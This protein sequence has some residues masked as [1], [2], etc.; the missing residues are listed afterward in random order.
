MA[1]ITDMA[2]IFIKQYQ[3]CLYIKEVLIITDSKVFNGL[4]TYIKDISCN[5]KEFK[6]LL[7][8]FLFSNSFYTLEG[9]FQYSDTSANE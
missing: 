8:N 7:K 5:V 9:Y 6:S 1:E 2:P 4:P 3:I